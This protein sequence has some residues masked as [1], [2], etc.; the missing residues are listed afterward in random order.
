MSAINNQ[1]LTLNW[2][3][4][5]YIPTIYKSISR[6]EVHQFMEK[7][8]GI[9]SRIDFV[10]LN[11]NNRR[12]FIHFSEW[13]TNK[14]IGEIVRDEIEIHGFCDI[15]LPNK[16]NKKNP[17]FH[18]RIF[19]NKNPLSLTEFKLKQALTKSFIRHHTTDLKVK[20]L[21]SETKRLENEIKRLDDVIVVMLGKIY[22]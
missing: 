15:N 12:V 10:D 21:Q 8:L 1:S 13:Y 7:N 5:I 9:V 14:G 4:S 18:T 19:I 11:E 2:T 20:F 22:N 16:K 6:D 17:I 3:N